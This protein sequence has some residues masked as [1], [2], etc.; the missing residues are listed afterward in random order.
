MLAVVGHAYE[1]PGV[2][3]DGWGEETGRS[4][5]EGSRACPMTGRVLAAMAP[6]TKAIRR[7]ART[8]LPTDWGVNDIKGERR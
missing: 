4:T 5:A 8:I 6:I 2:I 1:A 7:P 3:H